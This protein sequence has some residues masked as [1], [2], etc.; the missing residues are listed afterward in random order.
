[1]DPVDIARLCHAQGWRGDDLVVAVAVCLGESEANEKAFNGSGQDLSYGLF[2]INMRGDLGPDRRKRYGLASN[3]DLYVPETNVRVA[4]DIW[5]QAGFRPWGAYTSGGYRKYGRYEK[6]KGA[7]AAMGWRLVNSLVTLRN[8]VNALAP[9]RDKSS[10][11]TIGDSAHS[12]RTSDHNPESDGTVDALDIDHDPANGCDV[13]K[14]F[15]QI[16]ANKDSRVKYLIRKGKICAGR[17][18]PQPWVWRDRGTDDATDHVL[19][20][21]ISVL[22]EGQDDT[23]PWLRKE[24]EVT[25]DQYL[26]LKAQLD[27]IEVGLFSKSAPEAKAATGRGDS[28]TNL[29]ESARNYA[30]I[31]VAQTGPTEP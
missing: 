22:D 23:S 25:L 11:G 6:A 7:V 20:G 10:D 24:D 21:H 8:E 28:L 14:I 27:R 29:A 2:Q 16:V 1:M 9:N 31:A 4:Y 19:H 17:L 13:D 5:R 15:A 3:E 12:S 26:Q 18:G 30:R